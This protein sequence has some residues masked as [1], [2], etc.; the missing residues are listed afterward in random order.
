MSYEFDD[1][2]ESIIAKLREKVMCKLQD[3]HPITKNKPS[4]NIYE[5]AIARAEE[6]QLTEDESNFAGGVF[7]LMAQNNLSIS[8]ILKVLGHLI[9][10]EKALMKDGGA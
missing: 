9:D 1:S 4:F 6:L 2:I 3:L 10:V 7:F 8:S 5:Y